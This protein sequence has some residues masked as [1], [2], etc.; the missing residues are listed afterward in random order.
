MKKISKRIRSLIFPVTI[1]FLVVLVISY[2]G[3]KS[4]WFRAPY[5]FFGKE[6][7]WMIGLQE[8]AY[9]FDVVVPGKLYRS[10]KPDERFVY[11]IHRKYGVKHIISFT[12]KEKSHDTSRK[13]GM[14]VKVYEWST[15]NLPPDRELTGVVDFIHK[16]NHTLVHC[17]GGSD[18]TG[19]TVA[20]YR[21][22]RQN[23]K[24]EK[25]IKEM[26]TYWHQPEKKKALHRE[27][28]EMLKANDE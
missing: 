24:L 14:N 17:A 11:Y 1:M 4:R 5:P 21:V 15:K 13:L 20:F 16:N 3:M 25:A 10:G 8:Q 27:I 2:F 23:W 12:G 9:N 22:W 7:A 28:K 18:R 26:K 6:I 19:Y